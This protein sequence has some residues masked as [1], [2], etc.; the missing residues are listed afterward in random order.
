[1]LKFRSI[2]VG[3]ISA[4]TFCLLQPF[5]AAGGPITITFNDLTE[6]P[7]ITVTG[8][9]ADTVRASFVGTGCVG[10]ICTVTLAAPINYVSG[11]GVGIIG[12]ANIFGSLLDDGATPSDTYLQTLNTGTPTQTNPSGVSF[13]LIFNSTDG[14][15]ALPPNTFSLQTLTETGAVQPLDNFQWAGTGVTDQVTFVSDA[16]P[17]P[18]TGLLMLVGVALAGISAGISRRLKTRS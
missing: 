4:L 8:S 11:T 13:T 14:V 17:E 16:V 6:S 3:A 2:P 9:P 10:E 12:S 18:S 15:Q 1:M 5:G 7:F